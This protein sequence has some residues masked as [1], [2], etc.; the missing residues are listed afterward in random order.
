MFREDENIISKDSWYEFKDLQHFLM[1]I[2]ERWH[3]SLI[4]LQEEQEGLGNM[5]ELMNEYKYTN[6]Q[7]SFNLFTDMDKWGS[8]NKIPSSFEWFCTTPVK[9]KPIRGIVFKE[10]LVYEEY[11]HDWKD[12]EGFKEYKEVVGGHF[13]MK[14]T[15]MLLDSYLCE[16][17]Q[18]PTKW[19]ECKVWTK[20]EA[21]WEE[22]VIIGK[23]QDEI[24]PDT[25]FMELMRSKH[26]YDQATPVGDTLIVLGSTVI[27]D[28][29]GVE[30]SL[31]SDITY[32]NYMMDFPCYNLDIRSASSKKSIRKFQ[33]KPHDEN[34]TP[35]GRD[36]HILLQKRM[37][38]QQKRW[39]ESRNSS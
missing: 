19:E 1:I 24:T 28:H 13:Y 5:S 10:G 34:L 32:Y 33:Y 12:P 21:E 39:E 18:E 23:E 3:T 7:V 25:P 27:P 4:V 26:Y 8:R 11:F 36:F 29:G 20:P 30:C 6:T 37:K 9:K 16:A 38:E 14:T 22:I 17:L 2:E 31:K 35:E 15:D